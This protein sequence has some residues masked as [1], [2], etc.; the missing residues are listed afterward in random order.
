MTVLKAHFL[1]MQYASFWWAICV[2][3]VRNLRH[4]AK[5]SAANQAPICRIWHPKC[6]S[7]TLR[8]TIFCCQNLLFAAFSP[9]ECP[10]RLM[11]FCQD[12]S[13]II[14]KK[15]YPSSHE[16]A[17]T[18]GS[19]PFNNCGTVGITKHRCNLPKQIR[20]PWTLF[21][22]A[23]LCSSTWSARASHIRA[24][25]PDIQVRTPNVALYRIFNAIVLLT[26]IF[27][28]SFSNPDSDLPCRL[29]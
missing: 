27:V 16:T 12:N 13:Q 7:V 1:W 19:M 29:W 14:L 6:W 5:Q 21:L 28:L 3:L 9:V 22:T 15:Q 20:H 26:S 25:F 23:Y 10:K 4:I 2:I 24:D 17:V 11:M 8:I 18:I